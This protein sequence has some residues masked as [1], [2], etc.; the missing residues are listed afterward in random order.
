[1]GTIRRDG[2]KKA[3]ASH[4]FAASL[5]F[6]L[7]SFFLSH[8]G[9]SSIE[10]WHF[11]RGLISLFFPLFF[12]YLRVSTLFFLGIALYSYITLLGKKGLGWACP[13]YV[14]RIWGLL[15]LLL[16]AGPG[17]LGLD[18]TDGRTNGTVGCMTNKG[19]ASVDSPSPFFS[20]PFLHIFDTL[21]LFLSLKVA[22][23]NFFFF[24]PF[25]FSSSLLFLLMSPPSMLDFPVAISC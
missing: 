2:T 5:T 1:M 3:Y 23:G 15:L 6:F 22:F 18:G 10:S 21:F 9:H 14:I 12:F 7:L 24:I 4:R 19:R 11:R 13:G 16:L 25:L 8:H 17:R 20:L